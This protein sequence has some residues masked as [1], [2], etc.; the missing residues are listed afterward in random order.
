[1]AVLDGYMMYVCMR[2]R[3]REGG[4]ERGTMLTHITPQYVL[5]YGCRLDITVPSAV[6]S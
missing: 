6:I 5:C 2:E 1:M 3:G 4:R